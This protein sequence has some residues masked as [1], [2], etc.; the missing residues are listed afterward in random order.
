MR[1]K[2]SC[3]MRET[4]VTTCARKEKVCKKWGWLFRAGKCLNEVLECAEYRVDII[5]SWVCI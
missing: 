1:K 5:T 4:T 3:S 2:R